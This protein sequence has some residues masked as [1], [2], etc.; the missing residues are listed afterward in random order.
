M[1]HLGTED[2][3]AN[4]IPFG[5]FPEK[6]WLSLHKPILY[7]RAKVD[8][9]SQPQ[10]MAVQALLLLSDHGSLVIGGKYFIDGVSVRDRELR[11]YTT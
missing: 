1:V 8:S 5:D 11:V 6:G 9:F 7:K 2:F 3:F 10:E 4:T